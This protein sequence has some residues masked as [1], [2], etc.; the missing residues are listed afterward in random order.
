MPLSW[1]SAMKI[2]WP[3]HAIK[4]ASWLRR[5]LGKT[6]QHHYWEQY[7]DRED[8]RRRLE[9]GGFDVREV[10][11]MDHTHGFVSFSR[12][13]RDPGRYDEANALGLRAGDWCRRHLPWA[14]A[15]QMTYICY[16]RPRH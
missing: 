12:I 8:L 16:K 15:A 1:L 9:A 4:S 10:H 6:E 5:L 3:I 13:F 2:A 7:F 11:P 14:T